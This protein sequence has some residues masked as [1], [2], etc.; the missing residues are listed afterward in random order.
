[1]SDIDAMQ[2]RIMAAL[3]RIGQ[4]LDSLGNDAGPDDREDSEKLR[5][6]LE[7]EKLA[8]AQ[9]QERVKQLNARLKDA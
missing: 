9:L 4:G 8:N 5:Q 1:M 6:E 2:G 3:D 7:D